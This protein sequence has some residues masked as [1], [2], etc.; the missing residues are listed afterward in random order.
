M[1]GLI[2]IGTLLA[3]P[4]LLF[5]PLG[6]AVIHV[7]A[8]QPSIQAGMDAAGGGDTVLVA[9]GTWSGPGNRNLDFGGKAITVASAGGPSLCIIDC[10]G[11]H[12]NGFVLDSNEGRNSVIRGFAI[13]N[14][15]RGIYC[16]GSSPAIVGNVITG[17]ETGVQIYQDSPLITG[18]TISGCS[19]NGVSG[20]FYTSGG[21]GR[22]VIT[23][24]TIS[25]NS[26]DGISFY[27]EYGSPYPEIVANVIE[28]NS[29]SGIDAGG[30]ITLTVTGNIVSGNGRS[31]IRF[32]GGEA[33]GTVEGNVITG[34]SAEFGGGVYLYSGGVLRNNL[35]LNNQASDSGGGICARFFMPTIT[36]CTVVGNSAGT[37]GG[38]LYFSGGFELF[39]ASCIFRENQA[40]SAAEIYADPVWRQGE[41]RVRYSNIS[42]GVDGIVLEDGWGQV[43]L[44]PGLIDADPLFVAGPQGDHYLSQIAAGQDAESPSV[45]TGDPGEVIEGT[46]RTDEWVDTGVE[47][48]GYHYQGYGA[49]CDLDG[50]GR[51]DGTDLAILG[52]AFGSFIGDWRYSAVADIDGSGSV[53][54]DD[55]ALL[56]AYFGTG[57]A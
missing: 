36:N 23:G 57:S 16:P 29:G 37:R 51:V 52:R 10:G 17:F 54:G 5:T 32:G 25:S 24:N 7:P 13:R 8:D 50:S 55:L 19:S 4:L 45:D 9:D 42:G 2:S 15:F 11:G 40:P 39:V 30:H 41:I 38:G 31:G 28:G 47:D 48:Q 6:A 56:A 34:N 14:G 12:D 27:S 1:R 21:S 3:L 22:P 35:I 33:S 44:G 18:N 26:G 43:H 46:T 53:D 49:H 20:F